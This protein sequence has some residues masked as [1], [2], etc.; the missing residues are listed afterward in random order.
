MIAWDPIAPGEVL[1]SSINWT[2]RLAPGDSITNS[3]WG[4]VTPSG[5]T[6]TPAATQ[7]FYTN[8]FV[9]GA[10]AAN[11]G[12]IYTIT[13]TITTATGQTEVETA[14]FACAAK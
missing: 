4:P 10:V 8:I 5:L 9:S 7:G 3:V 6:V 12:T 2:P 11:I 13:N 14:T 1:L